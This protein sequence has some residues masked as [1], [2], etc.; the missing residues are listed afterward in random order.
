[1]P[2][3]AAYAKWLDSGG[4]MPGETRN[5]VS[6][7]AGLTYDDSKWPSAGSTEPATQE[8][9]KIE[10]KRTPGCGRTDG[11]AEEIADAV[12]RTI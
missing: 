3:P 5:Y 6:A 10:A 12:H 2:G 4:Y 9:K 1:M 11:D 8:D 7:I